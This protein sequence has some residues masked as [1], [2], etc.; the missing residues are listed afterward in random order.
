MGAFTFKREHAARLCGMGVPVW[1]IG[2]M[3]SAE[4][5]WEWQFVENLDGI[6]Q[7][8][9]DMPEGWT[10]TAQA[11]SPLFNII[12]MFSRS[13]AD[14]TLVAW[15]PAQQLPEG[16][17]YTAQTFT[18]PPALAITQSAKGVSATIFSEKL[19]N[20]LPR[21]VSVWQSALEA[22]GSD[23]RSQKAAV[24]LGS[25][26]PDPEFLF[27]PGAPSR[28]FF[29]VGIWLAH[30]PRVRQLLLMMDCSST[31]LKAAVWRVL[32]DRQPL[33]ETQAT[34]GSSTTQTSASAT[35][36]QPAQPAKKYK[37]KLKI[38][39]ALSD[40]L[41]TEIKPR[42]DDV[43]Q[44]VWRGHTL[45]KADFA[46]RTY[47]ESSIGPLREIAWELGEMN[48]RADL[49]EIDEHLLR[50]ALGPPMSA[51][52]LQQRNILA[53]IAQ[54]GHPVIPRMPPRR[55]AGLWAT[56]ISDR[57]RGLEGFRKFLV[58]WPHTPAWL[59]QTP[60]LA[61]DTP[62]EQLLEF[63]RQATRYYC[64]LFFHQFGRPP[65]VPRILHA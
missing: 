44:Y 41:G 37:Q 29:Y 13:L 38:L 35:T 18:Q 65:A 42:A 17:R 36:A 31:P 19:H 26:L 11:G 9:G 7:D 47:L 16:V 55:D 46:E 5:S 14:R 34:S 33:L 60:T 39:N 49:L 58:R 28:V 15:Q 59:A 2:D 43:L 54:D 62:E 32:F 3:Q 45:R 21:R 8:R 30:R 50:D 10:R 27:T 64:C 4:Q 52:R 23:A 24:S 22:I 1:E 12:A 53:E 61:A 6:P 63:E 48:F 57:A 20:L 56:N 51:A 25:R 40:L